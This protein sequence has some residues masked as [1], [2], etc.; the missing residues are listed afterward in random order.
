MSLGLGNFV[1]NILDDATGH[2]LLR[3]TGGLNLR[4]QGNVSLGLELGFPVQGSR[5]VSW[6]WF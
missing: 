3:G 6:V 2:G 1:T 4:T 5:R